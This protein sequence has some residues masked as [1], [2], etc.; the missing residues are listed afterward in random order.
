M[1]TTLELPFPRLSEG[2]F[3]SI[4]AHTDEELFS[5]FGIRIAF[6]ERMGGVSEGSYA[7]LNL[8]SRVS[9]DPEKVE[10]N[11]ARLL[12]A[13]G[14]EGKVCLRPRQVHGTDIALVEAGQNDYESIQTDIDRGADGIIIVPDQVATLLCFADCV[15]VI[16][17][18][19]SS[20]FAVVHAGWKGMVAGIAQKAFRL[21]M[22]HDHARGFSFSSKDYNVYVGPYIH[23]ECFETGKDVQEAF[24][25]AFGPECLH[26]DSHIDLGRALRCSLGKEGVDQARI[27]DVNIC[28]VC[29]NDRFFSYR[30]Q[31]GVCGRH[32]AFAVRM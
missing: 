21:L 29:H 5:R 3:A 12:E 11:Q 28:T 9:D 14:F 8:G 24:A 6:T 20:A 26:G 32:G 22:D 17:V 13:F 27:A 1:K 30:A 23:G 19:P 18:S 4:C 7:S 16:I 15:P 25:D 31:K 10:E 2:R